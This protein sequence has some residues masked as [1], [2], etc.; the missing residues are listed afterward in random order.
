[1]NNI[2]AMARHVTVT[3]EEAETFI[4]RTFPKSLPS[5]SVVR[6]IVP[7][8]PRTAAKV[9]RDRTFRVLYAGTFSEERN[10]C[11]FTEALTRVVQARG[12]SVC[13]AVVGSQPH[14]NS[15]IRQRLG[16]C[17]AFRGSPRTSEIS[18]EYHSADMSLVVDADDGDPVFLATKAAESVRHGRRVLFITPER[19]PA[20][21]L[22]DVGWSSVRFAG[23]DT[24]SITDALNGL[25]DVDDAGVAEDLPSRSLATCQFTAKE[26]AASFMLTLAKLGFG[27]ASGPPAGPLESQSA[28]TCPCRSSVIRESGGTPS[29]DRS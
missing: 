10:P 13:F 4:R 20:R 18:V 14:W 1:M 23:H 9:P 11:L 2:L 28:A 7:E 6:N 8:W 5:V 29:C 19:S 24:Q 26:V 15:I 22:F 3:T 25:L 21:R 27:G 12:I 16:A 17:C